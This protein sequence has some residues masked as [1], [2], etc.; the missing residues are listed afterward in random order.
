ML[1]ET[2]CASRVYSGGYDD[3][4]SSCVQTYTQL[5]KLCTRLSLS[6][7]AEQL[8]TDVLFLLNLSDSLKLSLLKSPH[9][10]ALLYTPSFE[11]LGITPLEGM[12]AGLPVLAVNNGGPLETVVDGETGYLRP[13]VK[14][15]WAEALSTLAQ[16][17][18]QERAEIGRA[19]KK[20]VDE[21]FS[22][23]AMSRGF[24]RAIKDI[25]DDEDSGRS[26]DIWL[27]DDA[28]RLYVALVMGSLCAVCI[29][30]LLWLRLAE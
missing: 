4:I 23:Q 7:S 9:T 17:S 8:D 2:A 13:A 20:R 11:H 12:A 14:S 18:E 25:V 16:L 24:E 6:H 30:G 28:V 29:G 26:K 1:P 21:Y 5:Q 27:E 15:V 10:L 22:K 19:G 3:R